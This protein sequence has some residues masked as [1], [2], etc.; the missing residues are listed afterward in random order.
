M[1]KELLM[2]LKTFLAIILISCAFIACKSKVAYNYSEM[3]VKKERSLGPD[4]EETENKAKKYFTESNYDSIVIASKKMEDKIEA[5]LH[6][7]KNI[8]SPN[9][10]EGENF[11]Q[12]SIRY[13]SFLKNIYTSYKN[14]G[15]QTTDDGRFAEQQKIITL[16]NQKEE[17]LAEM[18][19]A[20]RKYAKAN[21]LRM[22]K[23]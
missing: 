1:T 21:G 9:V 20:Q 7:L 19:A 11:K 13:F 10:P 6:D 14:F 22:E 3:I 12:A 23:E 2:N 5:A 16:A 17:V 4:I 8:A 18:Q 15:L